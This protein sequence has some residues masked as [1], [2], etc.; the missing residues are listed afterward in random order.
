MTALDFKN[1][2]LAYGINFVNNIDY[3]I[4]N[5]DENINLN[6]KSL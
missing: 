4:L 3:R 1:D 6:I 2:R 5:H